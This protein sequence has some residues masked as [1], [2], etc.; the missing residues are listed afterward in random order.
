MITVVIPLYN[1]EKQIARTLRSVLA[2]TYHD[3]EVVIVND[4][5]TDGSAEEVKKF[6]DPRIRLISQENGGVSAARNRGIEEARGEYVAFLDADD[7]WKEGHLANLQD[8]I[9]HYPQCKARATAYNF[10]QGGKYRNMILNKMPFSGEMG[11]LANYF[12][13][14]SVSH[15]PVHSSAVCINKDILQCIGGFPVGVTSGEDLLTWAKIALCTNF[16]Y[17]LKVTATFDLGYVDPNKARRENDSTDFVGE[18]LKRLYLANKQL[19]GLK[20]YLSLWYKMRAM[21]ALMLRK[22]SLVMLNCMKSLRYNPFNIKVYAFMLMAIL[23]KSINDFVM[24][25]HLR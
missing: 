5:S 12:E 2:Q 25:F 22:P 20:S 8:L 23:P 21:N 15:P 19:R 24:K 1:K 14:A 16:A 9:T 3:F 11:V 10:Q 18:E 6:T 7:E 4:G 13:V 17:S